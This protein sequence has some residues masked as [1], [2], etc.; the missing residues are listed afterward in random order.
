M[1]G[2]PEASSLAF[3]VWSLVGVHVLV[4]QARVNYYT[5]ALPSTFGHYIPGGVVSPMDFLFPFRLYGLPYNRS[6]LNLDPHT[7]F[8]Q[9]SSN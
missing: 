7:A 5:L 4:C 6:H 8:V 1:T 2:P 3:L 9:S